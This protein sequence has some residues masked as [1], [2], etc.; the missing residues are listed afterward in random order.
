MHWV[1]EHEAWRAIW[2]LKGG[3][4][5]LGRAQDLSPDWRS[6]FY[7][8]GQPAFPATVGPLHPP[9]QCPL[10]S[11]PVEEVVQMCIHGIIWSFTPSMYISSFCSHTL[12]SSEWYEKRSNIP[13]SHCSSLVPRLLC[14]GGEKRAWYTLFAHAQ[15][16]QDFW[17]FGNFHYTLTSARQADFSH[18]N[19]LT[20]TT[21]C[22]DNDEGAT[23]LLSSSLAGNV[24]T[25]VHPS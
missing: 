13:S 20:L 12:Q 22:M 9:S 16:P 23:Q 11:S 8:T 17:E 6:R 7:G 25:F 10:L 1:S 3:T 5:N 14:M 4:I 15:F 21:L 24:H 2:L 18:I 19:C